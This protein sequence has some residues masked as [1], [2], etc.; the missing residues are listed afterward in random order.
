MGTDSQLKAHDI[1]LSGKYAVLRPMNEAD[2]D[3]LLRWNTDPEVLYFAEGDDVTARTL[4][5]IQHMYRSISQR[6]Y[7]FVSTVG[8]SPIG[9]CWLQQMNLER[10]LAQYP[11]SNCWRIDLMIGEKR[12]W[13]QGLGT[14]IISLL[15]HFGFDRAG[16]DRIF[17][18]DVADYNPRSR[19]AFERI[20]YQVVARLEQPPGNKAHYCY[21]LM[22]TKEQ[23]LSGQGE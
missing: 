8:G 20:G 11:G 10:I 15:T 17:G 19:R 4:D 5:E 9:E 21:D 23:F 12:L 6:A 14:E 1:V 18:C 7:C 13:G 22:L 16:A 3:T 2:W